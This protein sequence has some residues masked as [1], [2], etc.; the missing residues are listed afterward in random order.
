[1]AERRRKQ[2]IV[3]QQIAI[4]WGDANAVDLTFVDQLHL[5]RADGHYLLTFGQVRPPLLMAPKDG[6]N[7]EI[8]PVARLVLTDQAY[9][10]IL[11]VLKQAAPEDATE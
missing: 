6:V 3:N 10:R 2:A 5:Q 11:D 4:T 1:M 8:R 9:R 7:A